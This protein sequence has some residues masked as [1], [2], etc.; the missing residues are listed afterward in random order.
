MGGVVGV[1]VVGP[2]SLLTDVL[3]MVLTET[4]VAPLAL[5]VNSS[6]CTISTLNLAGPPEPDADDEAVVVVVH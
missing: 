1:G 5:A 2:T 4:L 6:C 3:V